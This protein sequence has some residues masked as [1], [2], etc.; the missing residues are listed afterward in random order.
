MPPAL[1]NVSSP[2][3]S[4]GQRPADRIQLSV[5]CAYVDYTVGAESRTALKDTSYASAQLNHPSL[6]PIR[7]DTIQP[8]NRGEVDGAV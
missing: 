5:I 6:T 2:R 7:I 1:T 8:L 4:V 3:L